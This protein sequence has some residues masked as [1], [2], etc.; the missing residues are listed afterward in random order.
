VELERNRWYVQLYLWC[1]AVW[2]TFLLREAKDLRGRNWLRTNLCQF[3]RTIFLWAPLVFVMNVGLLAFTCFVL[4][5]YPVTRFGAGGYVKTL[6]VLAGIAFAGFLETILLSKV[7]R[8]F[9]DRLL[10]R[11]EAFDSEKT[12][13]RSPSFASIVFAWL[14]ALKERTCPLITIVDEPTSDKEV[15]S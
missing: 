3:L 12:S 6:V 11:A 15:T 1:L 2:D 7:L 10:D 13:V 4:V 14:R 8:W 5:Y 9:A